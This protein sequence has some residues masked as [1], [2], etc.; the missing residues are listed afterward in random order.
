MT[1]LD[2]SIVAISPQ[3][4]DESLTT[5]QKNELTFSVLSDAGNAVARDFGLVFELSEDLRPI[6]VELGADLPE[7]N[8][9]DTFEL[10]VPATF[11]ID[12]PGVI[13]SKFV[14]ADYKQRM[15]PESIVDMLREI[16]K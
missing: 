7:F 14:S 6:Y 11:I 1:A 5:A 16:A 10:P 13:R 4:P 15:E 9:N 3:L 12:R 2:A 8:G